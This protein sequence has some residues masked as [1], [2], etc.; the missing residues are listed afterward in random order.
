MPGYVVLAVSLGLLNALPTRAQENKPPRVGP[1]LDA[2]G[3]ALHQDRPSE[4]LRALQEVDELEAKG[5]STEGRLFISERTHIVL[6]Y[7]KAVEKASEEKIGEGA[8]G[9]TLRG[10]GPAYALQSFVVHHGQR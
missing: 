1:A 7:H 9:T 8:I 5:I 6:P 3:E 2:A 10:I 4:A